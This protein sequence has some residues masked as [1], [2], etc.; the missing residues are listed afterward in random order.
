MTNQ[1]KAYLK[2]GIGALIIFAKLA[3]PKP[4]FWSWSDPEGVGYNVGGLVFVGIAVWLIVSG[5]KDL[6]R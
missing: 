6:K 5:L 1:S 4:I 2:I 3:G